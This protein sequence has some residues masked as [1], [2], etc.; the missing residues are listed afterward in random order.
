MKSPW[1]I[2]PNWQ[3]GKR[4][5]VV[6]TEGRTKGLCCNSIPMLLADAETCREKAWQGDKPVVVEASETHL[7]QWGMRPNEDWP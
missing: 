1:P 6:A 5:D 3:P 7:R 4:Y 2:N